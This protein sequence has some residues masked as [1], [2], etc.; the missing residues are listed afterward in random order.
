MIAKNFIKTRLINSETKK[1][2]KKIRFI[3]FGF[4]F[5]ELLKNFFS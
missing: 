5:D 4:T 3:E 2:V 1:E